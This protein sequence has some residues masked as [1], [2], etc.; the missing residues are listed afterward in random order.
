MMA[1]SDV[2]AYFDNYNFHKSMDK[3]RLVQIIST[4][5]KAVKTGS[6][7]LRHKVIKYLDSVQD[8]PEVKDEARYIIRFLEEE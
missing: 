8:P 3:A 4:N 5:K 7:S 1:L 6:N 2:E